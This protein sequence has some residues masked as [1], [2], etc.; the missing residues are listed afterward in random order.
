[1]L[2]AHVGGIVVWS[3]HLGVSEHFVSTVAKLWFGI[4]KRQVGQWTRGRVRGK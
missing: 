1:M 2:G 3:R 4:L